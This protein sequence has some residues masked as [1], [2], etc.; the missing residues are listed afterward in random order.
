MKKSLKQAVIK[1]V[2]ALLFTQ[3]GQAF[4]ATEGIEFSI[5]W[6]GTNSLYKVYMR[7][8]STP[9][10]DVSTTAQVTVR[11]PHAEIPDRFVVSSITPKHTGVI[12]ANNSKVYAPTENPNYDYLSFTA[13]ISDSRTFKW[14]AGVE[15]EVFSFA[16]T[17][18]CLGPVTLIVNKTDPFDIEKNSSGTNPG[19][20]FSNL[21]WAADSSTLSAYVGNYGTAADCTG[22]AAVNT[23]PKAVD[24][25][26]TVVSGSAVT[27]DVLA[28][29]T[30]AESDTLSLQSALDGDFGSV[31]VQGGKLVY[32][33]DTNYTGPD[34]FTYVVSDG[35]GN[36]TTGKV[37]VTITAKPSSTDTDGDGLSNTEEQ[38][39]GT[40][41]AVADTDLDGVPD[42]TEVGTDIT[43]PL[44]TDGDGKI[45]ALD[46][47]DDG[48]GIPT[49]GEDKNLDADKNPATQPTDT[50]S[51][52]IPNYLDAD[53]DG[54]GKPTK[55]E[56]NNT[57][58][59]GNPQT[60]PRDT[61]GDGIPDPIDANDSS[62]A[63]TA[64][65]AVA[66]S[67]TVVAGASVTIDVLTN[68]TDAEGNSL[69]LL[70]AVD[71]IQGTV[72]IQANKVIY[73][74]KTGYTGTDTFTYVVTDSKGGNTTGTVTVTVTSNAA[75]TDTDGDGL[76]DAQEKT[77]GTSITL[78]DTDLDGIPD[79]V[80]VGTDVTK[81]VD[82]DADSKINALDADDDGDGV[83]T[84]SEDKNLDLDKNPATQP[85]DTDGD[86]K[87]D[88]LD[89]DDDGDGKLTKAEDDNKDADGNPQTSPLDTD[90]DLIPD[91]LDA[92]DA[93]NPNADDD[94]DGLTNIQEGKLGT[95]PSKAD[96]DGDSVPDNKEVGTDV[97]KPA[98]SDGDGV[99]NALDVDD[100]NDGVL[101]T[102]ENYKTAGV[103]NTDTDKDG[104]PD[105]LD[106]DDDGDGV[107]TSKEVAD[108]N[109]DGNPADAVD[110]DSNGVP[111]YLDQR[112]TAISTQVSVPTLS[113]WSQMLLTLLLGMFAFRRFTKKS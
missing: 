46:E 63:N 26:A 74:A 99:I 107:M 80:E 18:K 95:N 53:D 106:V 22:G 14:E 84:K 100:D 59:D 40:D 58:G 19:N 31:L 33:A 77:L 30:D 90:G 68:D 29:D 44:D 73:T 69:T 10:P 21:S 103:L 16:N 83:P 113:Q 79:K 61:D 85:T 12:W 111:D 50:D 101:T 98:D 86:G 56:D 15:Q 54:D 47:D 57:D 4:A 67:A 96:T 94:G 62:A 42:K 37:T 17:G 88:Y 82:T 87:A 1:G 102:Y 34:T 39:L 104:T 64:P 49:K 27:I 55:S 92:N 78:V 66:D 2:V 8:I 76:T 25:S 108:A 65:K 60:N 71:G 20:E 35:K 91:Y 81:P 52:T 70:S 112:L 5:R 24:D 3:A 93:S 105:Y 6:D 72:S 89:T 9:S 109:K 7:P 36:T 97:T 32:T 13:N 38:A 51:D 43:K 41:P 28:N 48:D 23:A 11:V 75:G 110:T 45:N